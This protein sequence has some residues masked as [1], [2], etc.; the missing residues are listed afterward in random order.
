MF[1]T[2]EPNFKRRLAG[3]VGGLVG[4]TAMLLTVYPTIAAAAPAVNKLTLA[5]VCTLPEGDAVMRV[6]NS[7]AVD[8]VFTWDIVETALTGKS[9]A[10]PGDSFL[11][12]PPSTAGNTAGVRRRQAARGEEAEPGRVRVPRASVQAV[13]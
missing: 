8:I 1:A 9:V 6:G 7:N 12:V 13:G 4:A 3:H 2:R 11:L 5:S 10:A